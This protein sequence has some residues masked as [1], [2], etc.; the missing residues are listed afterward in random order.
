[1]FDSSNIEGLIIDLVKEQF[2]RSLEFI[3]ELSVDLKYGVET[4]AHADHVTSSCMLRDATG[5]KNTFGENSAVQCANILLCD[6]DELEFG[7]FKLKA[8][9]TPGQTDACKRFCAEGKL[10]IG[11]SLFIRGC[12]RTDSLQGDPEK[13]FN[14][15]TQ[16]LYAY[17][18]TTLV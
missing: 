2:D 6:E 11:D 9:S 7:R 4:H 12:G 16:E 5:A 1:M 13:L 15:I 18:E 14:S 10:F 8:I 3:E 17:P